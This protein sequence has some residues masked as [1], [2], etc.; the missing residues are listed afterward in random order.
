MTGERNAASDKCLELNAKIDS[1]QQSLEMANSSVAN[2]MRRQE[3]KFEEEK[4]FLVQVGALIGMPRGD[5][6]LWLL[7][8]RHYGSVLLGAALG[9]MV[10]AW[11]EAGCTG[12]AGVSFRPAPATVH[13]V[14]CP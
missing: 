12:M 1:L 5:L 6:L 10:F 13:A 11:L 4:A 14:M 7:V 9:A 3:A 2:A 8:P